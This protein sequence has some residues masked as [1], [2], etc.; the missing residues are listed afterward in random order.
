M[1]AADFETKCL[2]CHA[3]LPITFD[4]FYMKYLKMFSSE[5]YIKEAMFHYLKDPMINLSVVSKEDI[6]RMGMMPKLDVT[7]EELKAL[8]DVYVK[9]YDVKKKLH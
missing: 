7:D 6:K 9:R 5:K 2:Q 4:K 1:Q 8:I 3:K